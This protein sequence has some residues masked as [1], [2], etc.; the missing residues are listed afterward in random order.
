MQSQ[1]EMLLSHPSSTNLWKAWQHAPAI[2]C[3]IFLLDM[4]IECLTYLP[5]TSQAFKPPWVHS[6]A[7]CCPKEQQMRLQI[8]HGDVT[9]I[10]EPEIPHV[11]KAFVDDTAIRGPASRYEMADGR[12]E[13]IPT[14]PS[15]QRFIWE[16]LNDVH[17]VIHCLGHAGATV[18][19]PKLFIAAPEVIILGHKCNYNGRIPDE[20]KTAK[21]KTWPV[22][23]SITDVCAFL[24]TAGTMQIWIKNY[25]ATTR[26]LVDLTHKDAEFIWTPE[27]D[28]AMENLKSAIIDSQ[29]LIPIDYTTSRP[30][31]LA[32]DSSWRA[33][34]WILSQKS[35]DG[36]RRP[37][38]FG[39]IGWNDCESRYSQ[40]KIELYGLFWALCVLRIHIIGITNLIVE[41]DAQIIKGMLSNPDVQPNA[42]MNQWI[43]AI[44]LFDF[45]LVH[46]P[47]KRH[48][49]PDGLS[50]REPIP[51]E[52]DNKGDPEEWVDEVL[53]LGIWANTR[54][55]KSH[56]MAS[57]FETEV[58]GVSLD[59]LTDLQNNTTTLEA[60][61]QAILKFLSTG[62]HSST[63]PPTQDPVTK[64]A[65]R[66]L[67]LNGRLWC[68]Q[69][70]G[71]NQL[72]LP[73]PQCSATIHEAHNGL[74]HK[75]FYSTLRTLLD[76]FWWPTL[77][78][79]IKHHIRTCHECQIHQTTKIHIPPVVA[80]PAPLFRKAYI[81]TM[82][83]PHAAGFRYIVQARCSLT[84]WPKWRAPQVENG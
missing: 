70:Q 48:L 55:R 56:P 33:V 39:S 11:A 68:R 20:L 53:A 8:F 15:I 81:D 14:N 5:V 78:D 59:L 69:A 7:Q 19:A 25:S 64:K 45:K 75:G 57:V 47:A 50:R 24:G 2:P 80:T 62:V 38:R 44:R 76:R 13:T 67:A 6:G 46:I 60:D 65:K 3:S 37:S 27:H 36:Q 41:M 40:P 26:P 21:I 79:D 77:A 63:L 10:L 42:A 61:L 49:G 84:M 83:M 17:R 35:E 9:F 32:V 22:C 12:Y 16:H 30:T 74:G 23:K 4:T 31:Y 73:I 71:W 72:I 1:S 54:P 58:G 43:A 82:L 18:S 51:G 34:G 28:Q 29:A 66:F 52:D